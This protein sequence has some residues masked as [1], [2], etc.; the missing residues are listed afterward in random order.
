[1][2][3]LKIFIDGERAP[4]TQ[5]LRELKDIQA[6]ARIRTRLDR[7]SLGNFGD[8]RALDGGVFELKIDWGP[9]YRLYCAKTGKTIILLLCGGDKKSQTQD[10]KQAKAFL[11]A[12]EYDKNS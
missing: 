11:K 8:H 6:R 7:L 5:W 9:G 1:M 10:I 12:Y 4:F 3:E 2:Y